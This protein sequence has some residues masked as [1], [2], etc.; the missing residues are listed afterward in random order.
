MKRERNIKTEKEIN[1]SSKQISEKKQDIKYDTRD[2]VVDYFVSQYEKGEFYIPLDY[3]RNFIWGDNE[4]CYFIE[5]ILMGL[6]IPFMFFEIG[7]AHV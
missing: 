5:S 6:P 3:Q 4:R 7:R 2:Y 1:G